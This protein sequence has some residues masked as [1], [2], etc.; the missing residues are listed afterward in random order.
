[1]C[2]EQYTTPGQLSTG[3]FPTPVPGHVMR[4]RCPGLTVASH[5]MHAVGHYLICTIHTGLQL[6]HNQG[7]FRVSSKVK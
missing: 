5:T 3:K 1:M 7:I 6:I 2:V 4:Q